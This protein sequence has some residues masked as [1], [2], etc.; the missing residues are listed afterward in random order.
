MKIHQELAYATTIASFIASVLRLCSC[1]QNCNLNKEMN[2]W[3][4][5]EGIACAILFQISQREIVL[6]PVYR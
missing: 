2:K 3:T 6:F 5:T 1:P 4:F